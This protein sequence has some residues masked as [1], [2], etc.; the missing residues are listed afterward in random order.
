MLFCSY[1]LYVSWLIFS[2]ATWPQVMIFVEADGPQGTGM[3]GAPGTQDSNW[4]ITY[5]PFGSTSVRP[6]ICTPYPTWSTS[7]VAS[8]K[9]IAPRSDETQFID[10][11]GYYTYQ[12]TFTLPATTYI[13]V[14]I[15]MSYYQ[16]DYVAQ[17]V[18]NGNVVYTGNSGTY[19]TLQTNFNLVSGYSSTF[20]LSITV[21]NAAYYGGPS[22][23]GLLVQ[24]GTPIYT[25]ISPSSMPTITPSTYP[26]TV[27]TKVPSA[28]P[29]IQPSILPSSVPTLVPSQFPSCNPTITP[30]I[31]P[32][33]SP[34]CSV[35]LCQQGQYS[36]K[37]SSG[38]CIPC[39][40]GQ[41]ASFLD[42]T[43]CALCP[44]GTY[45]NIY[46]PGGTVSCLSCSA[47]SY[48]NS[49]IGASVC[50]PCPIGK[51]SGIGVTVCTLCSQGQYT[52]SV[53]YSGCLPCLPGSSSLIGASA[54]VSCP[55]QTTTSNFDFNCSLH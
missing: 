6:Y 46:S 2:L 26:S 36:L 7:N 42:Q 27:P 50:A 22:P 48:T 49:L 45:N 31:Q 12:T 8:A 41:Y 43:S 47:G 4:L 28:F 44:M 14:T 34:T 11:V 32:S 33:A 54:C 9:W 3:S 55:A 19:G 1:Q 37:S 16:D 53:G 51:Y 5:T 21:Y 20:V 29:S 23:T 25:T 52:P 24:F 39:P 35:A 17:I 18:F 15:P 13:S 40:N 38:V 30:T 10:A